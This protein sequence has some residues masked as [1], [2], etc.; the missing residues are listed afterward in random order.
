MLSFNRFKPDDRAAMESCLSKVCY[1]VCETSFATYFLWD[2]KY[3]FEICIRNGFLFV[4]FYEDGV[5]YLPPIGEGDFAA[6]VEELRCYCQ[7]HGE[8][9][10]LAYLTAETVT[11]LEEAFPGQFEITLNRDS[12]EY[13]YLSERMISLAG[14]KLHAKR[15]FV[16]RFKR[17]YEGRWFFEPIT[18]ENLCEVLDYEGRWRRDNRTSEGDLEAERI[19]ILK[20]LKNMDY[21]GSKG[22]ILRLDGQIIGV[23]IGTPI[24]GSTFDI[25]IEKAE[26]DIP[27]TYQMLFNEFAKAFCADYTYINREDDM[28]LEGLRKAKLSYDPDQIVLKYS[29]VEI[30][31][32]DL[33]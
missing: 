2:E 4:R 23:S 12:S 13:L 14:K 6:A 11:M 22:G 28:G 18:P 15:N 10:R 1:R 31:P 29:A 9:L 7:E 25:Q 19:V 21:L 32:E 30:K 27:G 3:Q 26:W 16:N 5:F 33:V 20:L 24:C 17:E 8:V